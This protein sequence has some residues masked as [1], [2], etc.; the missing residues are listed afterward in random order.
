MIKLDII[1]SF[2]FGYFEHIPADSLKWPTRSCEISRQIWGY[3]GSVHLVP[4]ISRVTYLFSTGASSEA[5]A[6][7][8]LVMC[9]AE[10]GIKRD[11]IAFRNDDEINIY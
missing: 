11:Q 9:M 7:V 1:V 2:F 4:V 8:P 3:E 5:Q 6:N 10:S